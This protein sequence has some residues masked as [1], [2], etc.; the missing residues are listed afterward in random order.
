MTKLTDHDLL[1]AGAG[2]AGLT[3]AV[4]AVDAG[5]RVALIDPGPMTAKPHEHS[6]GDART[7]AIMAS[8]IRMLERLGV[9]DGLAGI[10]APLRLLELVDDSVRPPMRQRFDA[11]E[12]GQDWFAQNIPNDALKGA[13][14]A[15]LAGSDKITM[16]PGNKVLSISNRGDHML[17]ATETG[18]LTTRLLVAADGHKSPCRQMLRLSVSA[19]TPRETALVFN[20]DHSLDHDGVSYEFH[21]PLTGNGKTAQVT[22]IPLPGK[23]S[24]INV[25]GD[26]ATISAI[27]D[28][29]PAARAT[30]VGQATRQVLGT[31][32]E[33]EAPKSFPIRPFTAR[34]LSAERAV[35]IGEAAHALPPIG[36][37]GLNTTLA[38]I[39]VLIDLMGDAANDDPGRQQVTD[40]YARQ[41]RADI[42]ARSNA[43]GMLSDMVHRGNPLIDRLRR[44]GL[45]AIGNIGPLRRQLMARGMEPVGKVPPLMAK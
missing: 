39:A 21:G 38:D 40:S 41:R 17:V 28:M 43:T 1:I 4:A 10:S 30:M 34:R 23:R 36:A 15:R 33:T 26:Q 27:M 11:S 22:T 12:I 44:V 24:A 16:L 20:T 9:W 31:I 45:Q 37:Q 32:T 5:W 18:R 29:D 42:M 8:G 6:A 13:L 19:R 2:A 35:L 3:M 14:L 7:T 25:V